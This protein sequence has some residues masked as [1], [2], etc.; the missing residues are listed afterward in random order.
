MYFML[1]LIKV[2]KLF[3]SLEKKILVE[4]QSYYQKFVTLVE[5]N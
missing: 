1:T 4:F 5:I 3:L 2:S